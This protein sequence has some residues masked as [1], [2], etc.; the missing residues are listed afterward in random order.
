MD[1]WTM[2]SRS[3][4]GI[5]SGLLGVFRPRMHRNSSLTRQLCDDCSQHL[6]ATQKTAQMQ[7]LKDLRLKGN[8]RKEIHFYFLA[9]SYSFSVSLYNSTNTPHPKE[10]LHHISILKKPMT[11]FPWILLLPMTLNCILS[12]Q[13]QV[14]LVDLP[15][16]FNNSTHVL[17]PM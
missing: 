13:L 14:S 3:T 12:L 6:A 2:S 17:I 7:K 16:N 1:R 4:G 5:H 9:E 11:V 8:T 15:H 10:N